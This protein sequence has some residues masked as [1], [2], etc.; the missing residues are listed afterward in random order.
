MPTPPT[1]RGPLSASL[2]QALESPPHD[3]AAPTIPTDNDPLVDDDLQ[4]ALY[5]CYEL[6]Y[7]G[8]EGIDDCWEWQPSLLAL[9]ARL[10]ARFEAALL[11]CA[12]PPTDHP[13]GV[14]VALRELARPTADPSVARHLEHQAT[15]EQVRE[16]LVHRS[17]YHL[18]EADPH[19]WAIPR[20]H[21]AA[22]AAL[23]EIQF[24]E[25]GSGR[26]ARMHAELFAQMMDAVGLDSRYG[27][28]LDEVPAVTLATV[29]LMSWFG[30]HRRL[31]GA[32]CGHLTLFEMTSSLPNRSYGSGMRRLGLGHD[33]RAT[34]FFDEHVEADAAHEC[35]A[36]HD[37][38]GRLARTEPDLASDI[39]WGAR[40]LA[41]L[42]ARWSEHV[43]TAWGTG[44]SSL[45][46]TEGHA[47]A[48]ALRLT[49]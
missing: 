1:P 8:F 25:Y 48:Q 14:E 3:L 20:I 35:I 32:L 40:C 31:R 15:L 13:D 7:R 10:E 5:C 16:F 18:K 33:P 4:L 43:L 12:G 2:L 23:L 11:D 22:K 28:Y 46:T 9:R 36:L 30:L 34:D 24:D 38:S 47:A 21:G 19:S 37:L 17:A 26:H 41:A 49:A 44:R 45:R 42:D 6:H 27:A 39:I 29:N